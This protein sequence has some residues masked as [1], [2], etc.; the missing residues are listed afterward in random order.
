[1]G[2]VLSSIAV[3]GGSSSSSICIKTSGDALAR[4]SA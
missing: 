3:V 1:M 2:A 4:L